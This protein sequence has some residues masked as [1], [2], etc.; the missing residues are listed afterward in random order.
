MYILKEKEDIFK[1]TQLLMIV[2]YLR[3]Q[4]NTM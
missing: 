2:I 4:Y 1:E 3:E